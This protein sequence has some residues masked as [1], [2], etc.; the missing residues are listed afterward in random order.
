M[1]KQKERKKLLETP[2]YQKNLKKLIVSHTK[3]KSVSDQ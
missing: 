2:L 3:N 1:K